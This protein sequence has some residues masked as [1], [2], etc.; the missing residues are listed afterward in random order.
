MA[1]WR[2]LGGR[3]N[4]PWVSV[5][6]NEADKDK[7]QRNRAGYHG[8]L[9][10]RTKTRAQLS[11]LRHTAKNGDWRPNYRMCSTLSPFALVLA[12]T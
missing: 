6:G 9:A 5:P 1:G 7:R 4:G 2:L 3:R 8:I 10:Q 11:E 12:G